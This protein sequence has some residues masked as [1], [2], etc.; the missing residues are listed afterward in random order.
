MN[1]SVTIFLA[2][3]A[4]GI[5]VPLSMV[6]LSPETALTYFKFTIYERWQRIKPS[7]KAVST[8]E[9]GTLRSYVLPPDNKTVECPKAAIYSISE[10]LKRSVSVPPHEWGRDGAR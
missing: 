7:H 1:A 3:L 8:S 6:R 10:S 5:F 2:A 4:T 9:I